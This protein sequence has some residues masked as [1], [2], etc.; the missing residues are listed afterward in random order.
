MDAELRYRAVFSRD[1]AADGAFVYAV[2]STGIY[3]RPSCPSR[4]PKRDGITFFGSPRDAERAGFRACRRCRPSAP[5][6][7]SVLAQVLEAWSRLATRRE[8]GKVPLRQ[9]ARAVGISPFHLQRTFRQALGISP[10]ELA[11]ARRVDTLKRALKERKSVTQAIYEAGFGSASRVYERASRTLGMTPSQYARGGAGAAVRFTCAGSPVGRVLVAATDRGV[12]AVKLGSSDAQ[13][14]ALLRAEF[15]HATIGQADPAMRQWVAAILEMIGGATPDVRVP[16]DIRGTAFQQRVW[17]ELQRIPAGETR[18]YGEI[19]RRIGR[20]TA[21]RA[22]ARACGANP[23]CV[24][25]PCHR[26][27]ESGGGLG[28]YHWGAGRKRALLD[29]ESASHDIQ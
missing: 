8:D 23:V 29:K 3:C 4:K 19:A 15:P 22:V 12:C 18:S 27:V 11:D 10:R 6:T 26:V 13:L 7:G 25:V 17:K 28:G 9:L 2:R 14:I 5:D 24:V 1:R 16:L 21:A 20:P